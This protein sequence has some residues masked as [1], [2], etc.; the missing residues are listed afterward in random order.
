MSVDLIF[1]IDNGSVCSRFLKQKN[2]GSIFYYNSIN[3]LSQNFEILI[4]G[5]FIR[6]QR[7]NTHKYVSVL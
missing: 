4:L 3:R 5:R 1:L 2:S 7:I 6:L